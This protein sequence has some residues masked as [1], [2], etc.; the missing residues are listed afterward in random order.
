MRV[1]SRKLDFTDDMRTLGHEFLYHRGLLGDAGTLDN[2]VGIQYFLFCMVAFFPC[3]AMGVEQAFVFVL[4]QR[5]VR[6]E[7]VE[8][9][10]LG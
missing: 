5:H 7:H 2:L 8:T 9:L 10:L 4:D 3:N 6:N 1:A